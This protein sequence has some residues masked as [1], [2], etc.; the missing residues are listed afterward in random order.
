MHAR[1]TSSVSLRSAIESLESY[2]AHEAAFQFL[3]HRQHGRRLLLLPVLQ[4]TR[5]AQFLLAAKSSHGS[6]L[7]PINR[8]SV[9]SPLCSRVKLNEAAVDCWTN[10]PLS[11]A[12][13]GPPAAQP[14]LPE[15]TAVRVR[16]TFS[17]S[18]LY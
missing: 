3:D 15:L 1:L 7:P 14:S 12:E 16:R 11:S 13:R 6:F 10:P 17:W 4:S 18:P 2:L 8:T 5:T 9:F